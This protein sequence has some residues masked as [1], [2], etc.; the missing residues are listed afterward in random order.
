M[1]VIAIDSDK[2]VRLCLS[3]KNNEFI[4]NI[5]RK[6]ASEFASTLLDVINGKLDHLSIE[7]PDE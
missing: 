7:F 1:K 2:G 3:K 5:K 4:C 6:D